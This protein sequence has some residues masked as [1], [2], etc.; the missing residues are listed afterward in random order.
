MKNKIILIILVL[1]LF[2]ILFSLKSN[3]LNGSFSI[4]FFDAGK[5]DSCIIRIGESVVLID[6]GEYTL[7]DKIFKYLSDYNISKIDYLIITHFDKDHV[8]SASYIIDS[9]DVSNVLESNSLKDSEYYDAYVDSLNRKGIVAITV[10][11]NYSFNIDDARFVVNGPN[12]IYDTNSSNNSSLIVSVYYGNN[13]FLF[14]GDAENDRIEDFI[15]INNNRYDFIKIP[16]HGNYQ[17]K[18]DDLLEEVTPKYAVVSTSASVFDD[19]MVELFNEL[20]IKYYATFNGDI[21]IISDGN[22]ISVIQ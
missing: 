8:G 13:G 7:K 11:D 2:V 3:G 6:T 10:S 17:K 9:Y 19:K 5:A 14:M 22:D 15:N 21:D 1:I 4:H 16:Y 12:I 18:L 20:G